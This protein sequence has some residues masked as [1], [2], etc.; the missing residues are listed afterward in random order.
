MRWSDGA[1]VVNKLA[2]IRYGE[3]HRGRT[4]ASH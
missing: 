4:C 1:R 2:T 3:G